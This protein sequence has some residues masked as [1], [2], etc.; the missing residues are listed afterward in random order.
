M[1]TII[2]LTTY[3]IKFKQ[4]FVPVVEIVEFFLLILPKS[5]KWKYAVD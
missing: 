3:D 2:T 5:N 1:Y 4:F